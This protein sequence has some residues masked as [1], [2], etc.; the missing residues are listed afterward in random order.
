MNSNSS[1]GAQALGYIYQ[2]PYALYVILESEENTT[3]RIE[4]RDDIETLTDDQVRE[5]LELKTHFNSKASLTDRD[6][7]L[8]RS[9]RVWSRHLYN[10]EISLPGLKLK[11]ITTAK[12]SRGSIAQLLSPDNNQRDTEQ[13]YQRLLGIAKNPSKTLE[14]FCVDFR[15]LPI[16]QQKSLVEAIEI[17]GE[18]PDFDELKSKIMNWLKCIAPEHSERLY[19]AVIGWWGDEVIHHLRGN[20]VD[21]IAANTVILKISEIG[22][23][24]QPGSLP[25]Y[26]RD[27][28]MAIP[29]GIYAYRFVLQLDAIGVGPRR[30]EKAIRNY[31]RSQEA[32]A[33]WVHEELL[34]DREL[35][36]YDKRLKEKWEG[37][38]DILDD[39]FRLH[40]NMPIED[41]DDSDCKSFGQDLYN[42]LSGMTI[43][44]NDKTGY[45]Y[46]TRGSYHRLAN[47]TIEEKPRV[48]WHPR[49]DEQ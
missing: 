9:I 24:Y 7:D 5:L 42:Q 4:G 15:N 48:W 18:S 22:R 35:L 47:E 44:I 16:I 20:S 21:L 40:N 45:N 30:K 28:K 13:A 26:Y 33:R 39:T 46:I 25:A 12:I 19:T 11:L 23:D 32:R 49:F 10:G 41:A 37:V 38:F 17:L 14:K 2:I 3:I 43:R 31:F 6:T 27:D 36:T 34:F 29:R 8:W 1:A